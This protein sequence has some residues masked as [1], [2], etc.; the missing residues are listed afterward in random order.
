M[1][2]SKIF[3]NIYILPRILYYSNDLITYKKKIN[4]RIFD[5]KVIN[6]NYFPPT[7]CMSS[8]PTTDMSDF[9]HSSSHT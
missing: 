8:K 1:C 5:E 3:E 6:K 2:V 9:F 7:D 4:I